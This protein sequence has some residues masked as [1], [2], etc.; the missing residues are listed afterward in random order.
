MARSEVE[1]ERLV[2]RLREL[3]EGPGLTQE[4]LADAASLYRAEYGFFERGEREF[5][6]LTIISPRRSAFT[7]KLLFGVA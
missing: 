2:R 1:Q 5:G 4:Q 6:V 3:H 7:R